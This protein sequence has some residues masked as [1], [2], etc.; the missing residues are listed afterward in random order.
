M[1]EEVV[2]FFEAFLGAE[3]DFSVLGAFFLGF[4][5]MMVYGFI[6]R[7]FINMFFGEK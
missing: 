7:P 5:L 3:F 2:K 1:Y 6:I 4:T